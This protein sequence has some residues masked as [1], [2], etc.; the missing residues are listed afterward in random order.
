MRKGFLILFLSTFL[1]GDNFLLDDEKAKNPK[2]FNSKPELLT[3]GEL[4]HRLDI[5]EKGIKEYTKKISL[6]KN[7]TKR[8]QSKILSISTENTKL[9]TNQQIYLEKIEKLSSRLEELETILTVEPD[10]EPDIASSYKRLKQEYKR[11]ELSS[12]LRN[13][14]GYKAFQMEKENHLL[15]RRVDSLLKELDKKQEPKAFIDGVSVLQ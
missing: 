15:K 6:L 12:S 5:D 8:L 3:K 13:A 14:D 2:I 10:N 7:E 4:I 1:F 9:K 11:L